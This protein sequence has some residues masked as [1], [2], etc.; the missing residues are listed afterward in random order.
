MPNQKSKILYVF[1]IVAISS[2]VCLTL[3]LTVNNATYFVMEFLKFKSDPGFSLVLKLDLLVTL[4]VEVISITICN[5]MFRKYG[6]FIALAYI[7]G[8]ISWFIYN[9]IPDWYIEPLW[10]TAILILEFVFVP[11]ILMLVFRKLRK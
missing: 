2:L 10:Y 7:F 3:F 1:P 5:L 4:S 6:L 9:Q 8:F 11:L